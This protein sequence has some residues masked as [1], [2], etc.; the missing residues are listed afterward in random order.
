MKATFRN[1]FRV[2]HDLDGQD[3]IV[4]SHPFRL[5]LEI[6]IE[7]K[8][9]DSSFE[10]DNAF[11]VDWGI[12]FKTKNKVVVKKMRSE[13][14][15]DILGYIFKRTREDIRKLSYRDLMDLAKTWSIQ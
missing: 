12:T 4:Y 10:G 15:E 3:V 6:L 7:H 14:A 1:K 8:D 5:N 11:P 2:I 9:E 13:L